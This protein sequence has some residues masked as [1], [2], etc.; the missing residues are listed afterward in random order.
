M[1]KTIWALILVLA[2][3]S[4][5]AAGMAEVVKTPASDGSLNVRSGP[6]TG[7]GVVTWVKNGQAITVLEN[8]APWAKIKVNSTGKTGY[9]K[10][11]YIASSADPEPT[12]DR[13]LATV[14]TKNAGAAVNVRK[15]AGTDSAVAFKVAGGARVTVLGESGSWYRIQ[16]ENG[17]TGY[18]HMNY[19]SVGTRKTTTAAVNLREGAGTGYRVISVIYKGTP[20][21]ATLVSGSWTRVLVN[22]RT[23]YIYST[24]LK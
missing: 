2:I 20:V 15:G 14:V 22:G 4:L 24:Y 5:A 16:A 12:G 19:V 21:T 3:L 23:G 6:G 13:Y 17:K 11:K 18:I 9:I 7:Y 8:T 10:A 1:K